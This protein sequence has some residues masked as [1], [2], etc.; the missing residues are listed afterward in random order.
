VLASS[1]EEFQFIKAYA[2][3]DA[4]GGS[5]AG[6]LMEKVIEWRVLLPKILRRENHGSIF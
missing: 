1:S 6:P 5:P 3:C 4:Y 2:A